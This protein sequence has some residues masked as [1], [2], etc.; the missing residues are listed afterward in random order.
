MVYD[1]GDR[2][3]VV[4]MVVSGA[5]PRQILS[6]FQRLSPNPALAL[7]PFIMFKSNNHFLLEFT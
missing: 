2:I 7:G 4:R 3:A 1:G 5:S 6:R